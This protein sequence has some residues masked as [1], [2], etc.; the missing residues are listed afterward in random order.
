MSPHEKVWSLKD[1]TD[2][3]RFKCRNKSLDVGLENINDSDPAQEVNPL[4]PR[5]FAK[6]LAQTGK[7]ALPKF[8]FQS[9]ETFIPSDNTSFPPTPYTCNCFSITQHVRFPFIQFTLLC[10]DLALTGISSAV[11]H[12]VLC[13]PLQHLSSQSLGQLPPTLPL[14]SNKDNNNGLCL[15]SNGDLPAMRLQRLKN[16]WPTRYPSLHKLNPPA[17]RRRQMLRSSQQLL[18]QSLLQPKRLKG[19]LLMLPTQQL[20]PQKLPIMQ[21]I[22][23]SPS[24]VTLK[25]SILRTRQTQLFTLETYFSRL[26][27]TS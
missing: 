12:F 10:S 21:L 27:T 17:R 7:R 25:H 8:L 4:S 18:P 3:Y 9:F 23:L 2:N 22:A 1:H 16:K 5:D 13:P 20:R 15:R 14:H 11:L 6:A 24:N 19:E 26:Q